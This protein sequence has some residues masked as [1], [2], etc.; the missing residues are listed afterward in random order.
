MARPSGDVALDQ[1]IARQRGLAQE[2]DTLDRGRR[3][4]RGRLQAVLRGPGGVVQLA[5]HA[6]IPGRAQAA[7]RAARLAHVLQLAQ[8]GGEHGTAVAIP[9]VEQAHIG[10]GQ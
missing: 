9:V 3:A 10:P 4:G 5:T 8:L 7:M 6:V 2:R 1:R